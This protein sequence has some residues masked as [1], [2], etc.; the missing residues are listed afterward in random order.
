MKPLEISKSTKVGR[1][2]RQNKDAAEDRIIAAATEL[3]SAKGFAGTSMEQVAARCGAGKDTV[4]RRFPSKVALFE[5]VVASAHGRAIERIAQ[6]SDAEGNP[7]ERL[8]GMMF[9]FLAINM[10]PDLIALKR[11]SF[12]EAVVFGKSAPLTPQPD[13]L[14]QRL[15]EEIKASQDA[16]MI[17]SGDAGAI[18]NH[19]IHCLVAQ[20]TSAAML[21]SDAFNTDKAIQQHFEQTWHWLM[22]GMR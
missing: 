7:L 14:M 9:E 15:I 3:F 12:S 1:P 20:P 19:L 18:A 5:A 8:R 21:G 13:P 6:L 11:I 17:T 10:E 16:G 22:N 4:Y 2:T